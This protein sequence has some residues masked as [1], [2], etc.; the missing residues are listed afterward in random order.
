M[1]LSRESLASTNASEVEESEEVRNTSDRSHFCFRS[2]TLLLI[3]FYNF[4]SFCKLVC[5]LNVRIS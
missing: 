3:S 1:D 2:D 4:H 5:C